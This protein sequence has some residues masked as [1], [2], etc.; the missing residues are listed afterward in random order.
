MSPALAIGWEF[1]RRHNAG[2]SLLLLYTFAATLIFN[3][4]PIHELVRVLAFAAFNRFPITNTEVDNLVLDL[5]CLVAVPLVLALIYLII[6]FTYG[7][8]PNLAA[9]DSSFP[10]DKFLLPMSTS[11]LV[12]W[13]MLYGTVSVVLIWFVTVEGILRP[14]GMETTAYLLIV[15]ALLAAACMSWVQTINWCAVGIKGLKAVLMPAMLLLLFATP[16]FVAPDV[17]TNNPWAIALVLLSLIALA[18][19]IA[20][21]GVA[22]ARHGE[23][24]NWLRFVG[25]IATVARILARRR[26]FASRARA[27]AWLEWRRHGASLPLT[28][29]RLLPLCLLPLLIALPAGAAIEFSIVIAVALPALAATFATATFSRN[30]PWSGDYYGVASFTATRPIT[31]SDWATAKIRAAT[32]STLVTWLIVISLLPVTIALMGHWQVFV[33]VVAD[34]IARIGMFALV[35]LVLLTWR[36][37]LGSVLVGLTGRPWIINTYA[38]AGFVVIGVAELGAWVVST[39]WELDSMRASNQNAQLLDAILPWFLAALVAKLTVS[40]LLWIIS[41]RQGLMSTHASLLFLFLFVLVGAGALV[42]RYAI[43]LPIILDPKF[44]AVPF[45]LLLMPLNRL[46]A[47]PLVLAWN[48]H[49]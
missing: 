7:F 43:A 5:S 16:R 38:L 49:R 15:P 30:N 11:A 36:S 27:Q 4:V 2:L 40:V 41:R 12:G 13:P 44:L 46:I 47:M 45:L 48:R 42:V 6:M 1:W 24:P 33:A 23:S 29:S 25:G 22:R 20:V 37:T 35:C 26:P 9:K 28:V 19:P 39:T 34:Q 10:R 14:G 17:H 8:Q 18:Y 32:L 31:S 21:V 3:V